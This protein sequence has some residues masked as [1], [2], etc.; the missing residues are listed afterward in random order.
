MEEC[1]HHLRVNAA[2]FPVFYRCSS[3]SRT[4]AEKP[5]SAMDEDAP[6]RVLYA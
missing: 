4:C 5:S 6:L 1:R 2:L 3:S